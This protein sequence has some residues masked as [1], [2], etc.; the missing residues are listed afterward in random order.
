MKKV[1]IQPQT[2][3][4]STKLDACML[5]SSPQGSKIYDKSASS[6]KDVLTKDRGDFN[7]EDEP[8]YGDLW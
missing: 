4:V 6:S 5:D 2:E 8:A 7:V 3:V 1:Y